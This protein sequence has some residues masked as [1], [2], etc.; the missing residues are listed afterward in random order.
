MSPFDL[1][2]DNKT[3]VPKAMTYFCQGWWD[4]SWILNRQDIFY[5][6][7]NRVPIVLF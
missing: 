6:V 3:F 4:Q 2:Y 5:S 1:P 7:L